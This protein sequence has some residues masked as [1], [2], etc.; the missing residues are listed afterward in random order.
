M[1]RKHCKNC[2]IAMDAGG[3][4]GVCKPVKDH[5]AAAEALRVFPI[6]FPTRE[7]R[8][9]AMRKLDTH[10][11]LVALLREVEQLVTRET[12]DLG[13]H[14]KMANIAHDTVERVRAAIAAA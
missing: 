7:D 14:F 3:G 5:L 6:A 2:G 12:D 8:L 13:F 11:A 1:S 10:D 4:C 9:A